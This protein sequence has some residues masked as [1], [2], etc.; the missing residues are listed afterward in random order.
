MGHIQI[1]NVPPE[2]HRKLKA[3]AAARGVSLSEYL[4]RVVEEEASQL[5]APE[6]LE[7]IRSREG[8]EPVPDDWDSAAVIREEREAREEELYRRV[9]RRG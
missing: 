5:S 6:L 9:T 1:R 2:L 8:R 4:L 7:R 3:K